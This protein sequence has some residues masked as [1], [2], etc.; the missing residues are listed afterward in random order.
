MALALML[1]ALTQ[2]PVDSRPVLVEVRFVE[3]DIFKHPK[4]F[5][6]Y[7]NAKGDF[8]LI[9]ERSSKLLAEI[10]KVEKPAEE[11]EVAV[12]V[13]PLAPSV[14]KCKTQT[15]GYSFPVTVERSPNGNCRVKV[16]LEAFKYRDIGTSS[17]WL[18]FGT[19]L[20][21]GSPDYYFYCLGPSVEIRKNGDNVLERHLVK[22]MGIKV[23]EIKE[24]MK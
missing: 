21:P 15:V 18:A 22:F 3:F 16:T 13:S 10:E 2:A 24:E 7:K 5:E 9:S 17:Q 23:K 4:L 8:D 11:L 19:E 12:A 1:L 6:P 14:I 20:V